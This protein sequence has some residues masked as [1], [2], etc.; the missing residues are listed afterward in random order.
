M[1]VFDNAITNNGPPL[2][3]TLDMTLDSSLA[4]TSGYNFYSAAVA[5]PGGHQLTA[6]FHCEVDGV[7]YTEDFQPTFYLKNSPTTSPSDVG[8]IPSNSTNK[9]GSD[10]SS[11]LMIHRGLLRSFNLWT[12]AF[13]LT[14]LLFVLL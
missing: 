1:S 9:P 13:L 12:Y 2:N 6:D 5:D 14:N 10:K 11:S 8:V 3:T 4:T 7:V